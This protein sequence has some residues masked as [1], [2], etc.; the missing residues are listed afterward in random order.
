M[1]I[2]ETERHQCTTDIIILGAGFSGLAIAAKL[3][4]GRDI[5]ISSW[6]KEMGSAALGGKIPIPDAPAISPRHC[7]RSRSS[8]SL[9]GANCSLR[10]RKS[11]ITCGRSAAT[12]R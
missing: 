7:I 11:S 8:R 10:S 6:S 9:A 5:R 2:V 4:G 12:S 1:P 3:L